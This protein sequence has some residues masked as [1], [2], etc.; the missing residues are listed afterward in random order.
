MLLVSFA[1]G[2]LPFLHLPGL[3]GLRLRKRTIWLSE[4]LCIQTPDEP[5]CL[6][7]IADCAVLLDA[8]SF[9]LMYGGGDDKLPL[10]A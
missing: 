10:Q 8:R 2:K 5:G 1:M 6:E 4:L 3:T 7:S 9:S